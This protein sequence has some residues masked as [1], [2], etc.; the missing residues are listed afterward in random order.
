MSAIALPLVR[1]TA[2]TTPTVVVAVEHLNAV[3]TLDIPAINSNP[4]KFFLVFNY[5][6]PNGETKTTKIEFT[7]SAARNTSRTNFFTATTTSIA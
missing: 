1:F 7:S 5:Q 2:S 4:A 3:E 6:Y